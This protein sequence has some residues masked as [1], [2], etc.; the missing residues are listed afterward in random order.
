MPTFVALSPLRR[1]LALAAIAHALASL[2][3]PAQAQS[4][5]CDSF[6][7][8]QDGSWTALQEVRFPAGGRIFNVRAGSVLRP[9]AAI[10]GLDMADIL[11]KECP[12]VPVGAPAAA[13]T[14]AAPPPSVSDQP[15]ALAKF[16]DANGQIDVSKLTCAQLAETSH[17]DA[18]FLLLWQSGWYSAM[19]KRRV[20]DLPRVKE[21][22]RNVM[23]YCK[24]NRDKRVVQAMDLYLKDAR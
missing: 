10:L 7:R 1:L 12:N 17:A 11:A 20:I 23:L 19:A 5:P 16:T 22:I 24:A 18:D 8:N 4:V 6:M 13:L 2:A 15:A 3:A 9:G 21:G 14:P